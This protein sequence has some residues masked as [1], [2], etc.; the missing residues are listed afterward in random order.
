M[1]TITLLSILF[2]ASLSAFSQC[3]KDA[4]YHECAG[5]PLWHSGG[6]TMDIF[7]LPTTPAF[8]ES[9]WMTMFETTN[10]GNSRPF[11]LEDIFIDPNDFPNQFGIVNY[12]LLPQPALPNINCQVAISWTPQHL[13][14]TQA[15]L[16]F[17]AKWADDGSDATHT[18]LLVGYGTKELTK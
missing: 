4:Y 7:P 14:K 6:P 13:G 16:Y 12:C 5:S 15:R 18:V 1:K 8:S 2:L 3:S 17:K 11:I 9:Y 10:F